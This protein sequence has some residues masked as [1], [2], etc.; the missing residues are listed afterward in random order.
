MI[1]VKG[2]VNSDKYYAQCDSLKVIY[3]AIEYVNSFEKYPSCVLTVEDDSIKGRIL[4]LTRD[5]YSWGFDVI[6]LDS[7]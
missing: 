3:D 2:I 1:T 7:K 6:H 4:E 5:G